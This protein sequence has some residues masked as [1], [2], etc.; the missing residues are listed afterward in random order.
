MITGYG[1]FLT[2]LEPFCSLPHINVYL[3]AKNVI[4]ILTLFQFTWKRH[5]IHQQHE[6]NKLELMNL[7]QMVKFHE[8]ILLEVKRSHENAIQRRNFL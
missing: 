2:R 1:C 6:D 8:G 4:L 5:Q 3:R 7:T